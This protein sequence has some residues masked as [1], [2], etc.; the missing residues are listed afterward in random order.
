MR[1]RMHVDEETL[2]RTGTE[3]CVKRTERGVKAVANLRAI[4]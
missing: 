2:Q 3:R 4:L 1:K